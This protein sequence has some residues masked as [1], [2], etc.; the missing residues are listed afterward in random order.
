MTDYGILNLKSGDVIAHHCNGEVYTDKIDVVKAT[1]T[2]VNER[3]GAFGHAWALVSCFFPRD[4]ETSTSRMTF[5]L[6]SDEYGNG[7]G[8]PTH[9]VVDGTLRRI[10]GYEIV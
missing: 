10:S 9:K 5:S 1:G 4:D 6:H 2:C 3:S 7:E 8:Y